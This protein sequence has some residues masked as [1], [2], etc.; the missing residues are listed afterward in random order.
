[1]PQM[2]GMRG[3]YQGYAPPMAPRMQKQT[4]GGPFGG[5]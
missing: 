1:M 3:G 2:G 5:Y 4:F